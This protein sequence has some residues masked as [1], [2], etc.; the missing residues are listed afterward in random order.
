MQSGRSL[1]P[2]R[3]VVS[4]EILPNKLRLWNERGGWG[5]RH[6]SWNDVHYEH[7]DS[8]ASEW[9]GK[10]VRCKNI[11]TRMICSSNILMRENILKGENLFYKKRN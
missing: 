8:M 4:V 11:V 1:A 7:M 10:F 6:S 5:L 9:W 2:S 3:D